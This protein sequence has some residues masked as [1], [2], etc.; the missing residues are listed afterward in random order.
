MASRETWRG[1]HQTKA[2]F[3]TWRDLDWTQAIGAIWLWVKGTRTISVIYRGSNNI[4]SSTPNI[5]DKQPADQPT[6]ST[7]LWKHFILNSGSS[8]EWPRRLVDPSLITVIA[9]Q[10]ISIPVPTYG[11]L[12]IKCVLHGFS[13]GVSPRLKHLDWCASRESRKVGRRGEQETERRRG[14]IVRGSPAQ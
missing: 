11:R 5:L 9:W 12:L 1:C 10:K 13:R 2:M 4:P 7:S 14:D 8:D 6:L 3:G